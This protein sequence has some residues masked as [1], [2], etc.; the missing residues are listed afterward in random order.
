MLT[1][2]IE[3]TY[4]ILLGIKSFWVYSRPLPATFHRHIAEFSRL[5]SLT[6]RSL[7][8]F[9]HCREGPYLFSDCSQVNA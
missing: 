3:H 1:A 5:A 8:S 9:P 7:C 2:S 4:A 6:M